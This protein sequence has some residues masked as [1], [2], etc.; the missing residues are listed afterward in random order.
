MDLELRGPL[1][2]ARLPD[3]DIL[4][5]QDYV[6]VISKI[7]DR[8]QIPILVDGNAGGGNA[9]NTIRL[10]RE[11]SKAGGHG[12]CMEDNPFPKRCSFYVG[13]QNELEQA[14]TFRGKL[15]AAVEQRV[16][17]SFAVIARTEALI[18]ERSCRSPWTG[19]RASTPMRAWT[20]S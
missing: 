18:K 19:R 6:D 7:S 13:M 14:S 3:A 15:K 11:F 12:I 2:A 10:V 16:D 5:L 20:G 8:V 4:V 17:P 9:I 1:A